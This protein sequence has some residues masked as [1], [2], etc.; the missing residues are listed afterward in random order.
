MKE[1]ES[2][3]VTIWAQSAQWVVEKRAR[4]HR[5]KEENYVVEKP[6]PTKDRLG[7]KAE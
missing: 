1:T 5:T 2:P 3:S 4:R 6:W 7:G